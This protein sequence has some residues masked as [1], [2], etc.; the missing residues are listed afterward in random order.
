MAAGGR[1][2][3]AYSGGCDSSFLLAAA[4]RVLGNDSVLAFTAVS[5]SLA[6]AEYDEAERLAR[7]LRATHEFIQTEE[8]SNPSYIANPTNRCFFCKTELYEKLQPLA[9]QRSARVADGLNASDLQDV[10]PGIEAA[11]R[12]GVW[13][14]LVEAQ[15]SKRDIRVLSR[16]MNLP[17]WNKPASPCLSSRIPFGQPVTPGAL[18]QVEAAESCL[19][20]EG[21]SIVRVRHFGDEAR[22]EVPQDRL[23]ELRSSERWGKVSRG[24]LALGFRRV[25]ADPRGFK[26]GRLNEAALH[27]S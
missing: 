2:V 8:F 5:A 19:K 25:T 3:V 15:L 14:P 17:T 1:L 16:W 11:R 4:I 22:I 9:Q 6:K 10:R 26:S 27:I 21:F 20:A 12:N 24:L 23:P 7:H 13:H 18:R